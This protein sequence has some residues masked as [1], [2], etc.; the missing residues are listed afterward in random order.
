MTVDDSNWLS[1]GTNPFSWVT[2]SSTV[3]VTSRVASCGC[4]VR[5]N[6]FLGFFFLF[7]ACIAHNGTQAQQ[8]ERSFHNLYGGSYSEL[9][10][11]RF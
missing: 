1:Q 9:P 3:W 5:P 2:F 8:R 6:F 7:A 10:E 11:I 4:S